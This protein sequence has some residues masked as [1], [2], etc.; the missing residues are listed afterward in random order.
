M[1]KPKDPDLDLIANFVQMA[2]R[3]LAGGVEDPKYIP[4]VRLGLS[5]H[6]LSE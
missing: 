6:P 5:E 3:Y 4:I 2:G 1:Q